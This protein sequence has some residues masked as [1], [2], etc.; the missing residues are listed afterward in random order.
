MQEGLGRTVTTYNVLLVKDVVYTFD[1]YGN[2]ESVKIR[3][4]VPEA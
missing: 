3:V 4:A 2:F 1:E